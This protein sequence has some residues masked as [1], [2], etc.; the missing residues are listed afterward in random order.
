MLDEAEAQEFRAVGRLNVAGSRFC[1]AT[2]VSDRQVVTA[3][4][5]LFHPGSLRRV[6]L[7]EM[8]FV[9]GY[10][11]GRYA[12]VRGVARAALPPDYVYDGEPDLAAPGLDLALLELDAAVDVGDAV[13]LP[14]EADPA[15]GPVAIVSYDR[16]RPEAPSKR[17][18]CALR[19]LGAG[20]VAVGCGITFGAS[21]APVLRE[22]DGEV[23][24]VAVV[25]AVAR[26]GRA[27]EFALAALLAPRIEILKLALR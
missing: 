4:H 20:A 11:L 22:T 15:R 16:S 5:C 10:R 19:E 26:Q 27:G 17:D 18:A 13:P 24:I 23:R 25:S 21:G 7:T 1:T 14:P 3:A 8:R 12:A 2:L 9:A 6:P